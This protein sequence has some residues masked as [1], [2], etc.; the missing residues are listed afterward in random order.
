MKLEEFQVGQTFYT[1]SGAWVCTDVGKRTII[2]AKAS[3]LAEFPSGPPYSIAESIFDEYDQQ[4]CTL[5]AEDFDPKHDAATWAATAGRRK[6][7]GFTTPRTKRLDELTAA[8]IPRG[9]EPEDVAMD[10]D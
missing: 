2:A 9:L 3:D 1:G 8:D 6:V 4:G 10:H 7:I 5:D